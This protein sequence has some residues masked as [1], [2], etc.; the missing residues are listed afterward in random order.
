VPAQT[1]AVN[2]PLLFATSPAPVVAA[3]FVLPDG[4][5]AIPGVDIWDEKRDAR[6]YAG[7][8]PVVAHPP[9][10]RWGNYWNGGPAWRGA[11]KKLGDDNGCFAAALNAVRTW[12]GIMEHPSGSK[13]YAYFG[14]AKPQRGCWI[15]A[16][17]QGFTTCVEQGNYGHAARKASWLYLCGKPAPLLWQPAPI[18]NTIGIARGVCERLSKRQRQLT[19]EPFRDLLICLALGAL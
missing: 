11:P 6:K 14:L 3:L 2:S 5:Y 12:G 18:V 8:L 19:P 13:A 15:A 10:E 7:P 1:T 9:C 16:D 17:S 4:P